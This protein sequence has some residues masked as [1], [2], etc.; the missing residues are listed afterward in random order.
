MFDEELNWHETRNVNADLL[1]T[2]SEG[3]S[4]IVEVKL[5][6]DDPPN[7]RS[8]EYGCVGQ[9]IHYASYFIDSTQPENTRLFIIGS[10]TSELVE[11][12]CALLREHGFNIEYL[13][14]IDRLEREVARLIEEKQRIEM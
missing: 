6:S 8:Q 12:C 3:K 13:S 11:N 4:V 10:S 9:I 1:G 14:V 7:R 5:W 2:D